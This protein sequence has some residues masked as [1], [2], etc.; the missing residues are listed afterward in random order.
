MSKVLYR[1]T[2]SYNC[3]FVSSVD[4]D[5][6][7]VIKRHLQEVVDNEKPACEIVAVPHMTESH[8]WYDKVPYGGDDGMPS[9]Y[10]TCEAIRD[11][12]DVVAMVKNNLTNREWDALVAHFKSNDP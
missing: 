2:I 4:E 6:A 11:R 10:Y 8:P 5:P 9:R 1:G 3:Y 12:R 7:E